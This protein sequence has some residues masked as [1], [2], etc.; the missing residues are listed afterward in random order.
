M[1]HIRYYHTLLFMLFCLMVA[2]TLRLPNLTNIPGG[3][4]YDEAANGTLVAQIAFDGY[5]PVFISSYTGKEVLFFYLAGTVIRLGGSSVF[6]LRLTAVYVSLLTIATT[7]WLG[8]ELKRD[9]RIALLA[10]ALLA[11]SF[12]HLL[13]SRLGFRVN[14]QPLLQALTVAALWRAYR[15]NNWRWFM[16]GGVFLGLSAY[17]Y[18]AVRLFPLLLMV[19]LLPLLFNRSN[20]QQRWGQTAVTLLIAFIITLPLLNY[21]RLHPDA[22]WVRITQVAP[23]EA[24][25]T[26]P[27]SYLKSLGMLFLQGDP[28]MRFNL[29]G[30]PLFDWFWG[31][32]LLVGWGTLLFRWRQTTADWQRGATLL[33]VLAPLVMILP[34]ALAVN[35]IVPSNIR[36][37]GLIPFIFYLPAIG[38]MTLLDD[39]H[40]RFG[41]PQPTTAALVIA[42]LILMAGSI[43]VERL[44]FRQWGARADVFFESDGD[45]AAAARFLNE[46]DATGKRL[47]VA[48]EHYQHPTL[49]YLSDKYGQVKWL[50]QSQAVV[51]PAAGTAVYIF[52]HNSPLPTW[53]V[54]Y[55]AQATPLPAANAPDGSPAFAAYELAATPPLTISHPLADN[56]GRI[57]LLGYDLGVGLPDGN[58][59]LTLYWQVKEEQPG[60]FTPFVQLEDARGHRWSQVETFAYPAGQ[61]APGEIV[62]QRVDVPIPAGAPPDDYRLRVGLFSGATGELLPRL[63]ADGRYAGSATFIEDVPIQ[64]AGLPERIPQPP[65]RWESQVRPYLRLLGYERGA[66]EASTGEP[67]GVALW[68]LA[69]ND[70]PATTIQFVLTQPNSDDY[71]LLETQPVYGRYPFTDWQPPQ[72]I[73]DRQFLPIP[74]DIPPGNYHIVARFL[75]EE[76]TASNPANLGAL[77]VVATPRLFTPPPFETEVNATFGSEITLLGYSLN[78]TG[79]PG[80]YTLT[81]VWQ[82]AQPPAADYTVFVHLLQPDGTCNPC[83]WQQ[84]V[85]PQQGQYPT[86]RWQVGEVVIDSYQIVLPAAAP[87]GVYPLEVGLYLAEN[88]RRLQVTLPDGRSRE[89]ILLQPIDN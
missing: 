61:W 43:H 88:G 67:Y 15:L 81:L 29:P 71:L 54:P 21:F 64:A 19:G 47:Y 16:A 46:L 5:R 59:P 33:L 85:M 86:A 12:W 78:A 4:H 37:F 66:A 60:D 79:E 3:L 28:Y 83:A 53:A 55:F 8:M 80:V 18:L 40:A 1:R 44:Y 72:F 65:N 26:I 51:F 76:G 38:L 41:R 74:A 68:W 63:D 69:T 52:P 10:A 14:T 39:I 42:T 6:T 77:T 17:T 70:I 23:G 84:D 32:L 82:T 58:L 34:T 35:E 57:S 75:N 30:R 56:F 20:W 73:I 50:P 25:L 31:G 87:P 2:A 36:A 27:Q 11:V 48:A 13:F 9:R 89:A 45:L 24:S 49:A 62:V 7:Y 22:F